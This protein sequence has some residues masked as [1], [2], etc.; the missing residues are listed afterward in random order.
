M[1]VKF[2]DLKIKDKKLKS[3]LLHSV[4]NVMS[5]GQLLLGPEVKKF[6]DQI[7]VRTGSKYAVAVG[8]GS[9]ALYLALKSI[10]LK[11]GDE[12]IT[13]PLTWIIT[14]NAIAECRAIPVC[15]DIDDDFNID[16]RKIKKGSNK[17]N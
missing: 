6:E 17:K 8:S 7:A 2:F 1:Q 15:V 14:L 11:K 10:G 4:E 5:H 16:P 3:S 12:V 9:S 13:S